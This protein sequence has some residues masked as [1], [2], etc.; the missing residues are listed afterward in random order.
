MTLTPICAKYIYRRKAGKFLFLDIDMSTIP[1]EEKGVADPDKVDLFGR[2][3]PKRFYSQ[4]AVVA[5]PNGFTIELDGRSLKTPAKNILEVDREAIGEAVAE[6][7]QQ[8]GEYIDLQSMHLTKI[9]NTAVDRISVNRDEVAKELLDYAGAD[10]VCYRA[11][12]PESLVQRQSE[13]WDPVLAWAEQTF[14]IRLVCIGGVIHHPQPPDAI[15]RLNHL[16]GSRSNFSLAALHN[17]TTLTGSVI[18]SL[19]VAENFLDGA[20]AWQHAHVD[21]DWQIGQWGEDADATAHRN[22]RW[23]EMEKTARVLSLL[24]P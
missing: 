21:E 13:A 19:A 16:L 18:L 10:L 5:T 11:L 3:L 1:G 9:V 20:Q 12:E 2:R 4:V 14:G 17:M 8:Q 6:E 24:Q 15:A 22:K 7:W 23:L